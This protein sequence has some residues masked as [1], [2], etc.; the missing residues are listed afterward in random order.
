MNLLELILSDGQSEK[1]EQG[2][3]IPWDDPDFSRRMLENHLSQDHD[4]ASRRKDTIA[5]HTAWVAGQLR[6]QPSRVLDMG[7]GPGLYTQ[8]LAE[9][10]HHC[11]GV[12]FSPASIAY[13]RKQAADSGLEIEYALCD[14]RN[15]ENEQAFDCILMTFGEINVFTRQDAVGIVKNCAGML[16]EDGL[17]ILEAHTYEAVRASGETASSWQRQAGGLFSDKPHLCLQEN[18]WN[19]SE[20]TALSRYFIVDA[21][22]ANV[23]QYASFMQAY[24]LAEYR[25]MLQSA[26][27]TFQK[28]LG[29]DAWPTGD[30]FQGKL[31]VF[32]CRKNDS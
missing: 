25:D 21:A 26:G 11:V 20:A 28:I 7:C 16:A 18:S 6:Q 24:T 13:A 17:L 31:Q 29:A 19:A 10:G 3:K 8:T 5:R 32:A 15:Y 9:L 4:W 1:Y 14:I 23:C 22:S 12:D 2:S 30:I 27:L